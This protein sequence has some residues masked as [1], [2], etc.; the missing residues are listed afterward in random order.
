M[1]ASMYR[2]KPGDV[3]TWTSPRPEPVY[4]QAMQYDGT[5]AV[6]ILDWINKFWLGLCPAFIARTGELFLETRLGDRRV[7]TDDFVVR[8][9]LGEF[10]SIRPAIFAGL[11]ESVTS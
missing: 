2:L 1:T 4:V 11:Y 9:A 10:T 8:D 5:N 6:E 7:K 3:T